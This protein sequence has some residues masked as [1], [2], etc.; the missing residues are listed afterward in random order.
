MKILFH[1]NILIV[2]IIQLTTDL[3]KDLNGFLM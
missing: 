2:L 1:L 3:K